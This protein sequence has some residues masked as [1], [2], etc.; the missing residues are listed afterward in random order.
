[1]LSSFA[2]VALSWTFN[3]P[4]R[5]AKSPF[6]SPGRTNQPRTLAF[7]DRVAYQR[8]IEEVYWRHRTWSAEN[9][10]EKPSLDKVMSQAQ[11]EKKVENYLRNSQ[12]LAHYWR[13]PLTPEQLQAEMERMV[14]HTRQ[15]EV[16][17]EIF[18]A[19]GNDPYVIAECLARPALADRL[20]RNW[21]AHDE[22][23]HGD[24]KRRA[25]ADVLSHGSVERMK[26]TS[27][28]YSEIEWIKSDEKP[29]V[30]KGPRLPS[31]QLAGEV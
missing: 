21:Y 26:Q 17:R 30:G 10:A 8:A 4:N 27:G 14:R 13:Q 7:T 28:A 2:V 15:P 6:A 1:M 9:G 20:A 23:F 3:S 12:L 19:L 5:S 25:E 22:R 29:V 11:I 24:L 31:P 18:A 16:L